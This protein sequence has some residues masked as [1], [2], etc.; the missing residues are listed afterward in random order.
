M[1]KLSTSEIRKIWLEF[2]RDKDHSVEESASLI[3]NNDP[4]LL[5]INAGVAPLKKYFD[6]SVV[7]NN[8]RIVNAQKCIRTNDINNVGKTARH[9]TFFEMLGNF[10]IGDYFRDEIIPWAYELLTSSKYYD[11]D[12]NKLYFTV[13]PDDVD[14]IAAW[15][16]LGVPSDHIIPCEHNFWQI[17]EG[18]CGPDTEIFF[19]RGEKY[20]DLGTDVIRDDIENERY[21]EI[22]NIVFS[23]FNA[24]K[25][26]ERAEYPE[27]PS[28]NIDTGMG[29]ERMACVLQNVETNY[30]TDNFMKLIKAVEKRSGVAY[31][32]QMSFKVI[33]DHIRTVTFA[34]A[35]GA[36]LSNEGRGYVLR[37]LLRRGVKHGKHLGINKAFMYELVDDVIGAM[38]DFY[39]YLS[40]HSEIIK[41]IVKK[42]EDK[43]LETLTQGEQLLD[44][45]MEQSSD[46][47]IEGVDAFKLYDT[48]GFPIELTIE[49]AEQH[50]FT[51]DEQ[52]FKDEM[53]K[54][55]DRARQARK[56]QFS[57]Q[58]QNQDYLDFKDQD[59]FTGYHSLV[60]ETQILKVFPEGVVLEKTPFYAES[61]GQI[62]DT[63][64][65]IVDGDA[66]PVLDVQKM[67]N[68]QFLHQLDTHQ[69]KEGMTVTAKVDEEKRRMTMIHHSA[70]HLLFASLR[71]IVGDHVSQ[72]GS[73][74][75]SEAL[76]FDFNSYD[77]LDD[78]TLLKIEKNV[79]DK[80]KSGL[81]VNVIETSVD[82]A[83]KLGA[84]AEFGE[85]YGDTVRVIDMDYTVDL[86]G[87]THVSNTSEIK[88]LAIANIENKGSGIYRLTAHVDLAIDLIQNQLRG[89]NTEI[90][91]V[92][93]KAHELLDVA[94]EHNIDVD[95]DDTVNHKIKGSYQDILDKRQEFEDIA[96][97]VRDLD[98]TIKEAL[99]AQ[100]FSQLDDY[101]N[102]V[103]NNT[104]VLR[105]EDV[106]KDA[107]KPLAD[108][109]LDH[110]KGGFVFLANVSGNKVTFIAKSDSDKYHSGK[111]AKEAAVICGGNGGGR[112][113]MAQAGGKDI[114]KVDEALEKVKDM[115]Q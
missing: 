24:K 99:K 114:T 110:L 4:T 23:Q 100:T 38:E 80:I 17:G 92:I 67:P 12:I 52:G 111:I 36:L 98:K 1:K 106:D 26:L 61:G 2:F 68:G 53:Q 18:P 35:D 34:M 115:V 75:S 86:C 103:K 45:L 40:D 64:E 58:E 9:H 5:W 101:L 109:L 48:Y 95:F 50:G 19:D 13:Y 60:E 32:G 59:T 54:Q 56:N 82:E 27:L 16:K 15:E 63:G 70:T 41:K 107:L 21:I 88:K 37:R 89:L 72:Q 66:Y 6:G 14:T 112:P 10:S 84:I 113:Q 69:L 31:T 104:L 30:E 90:D 85:K 97:R 105:L 55:K 91:K 96:S 102:Q 29:L 62:G 74:V 83:K 65:L 8:P 22:W 42:E 51:V 39:P 20:G 76:R 79:N 3:P 94:K 11:M 87:G 108:R 57:M 33:A 7:P 47:N 44:T 71:E 93:K 77:P 43:F 28:K 78:E 73:N 49:L 46:K 25:G 81:D